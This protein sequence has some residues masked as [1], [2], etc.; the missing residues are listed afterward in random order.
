MMKIRSILCP[1]VCPPKGPYSQAIEVS[2]SVRTIYTGTIT[3][4]D[5]DWNV[6]GKGDIRLQ[7]TKTL[8]NLERILGAAGATLQNIVKMTWY[9]VHI[10]HMTEVA[11]IRNTFFRGHAPA[12][13]TIPINKLFYPD[14]LLEM[15]A[16]AV[17]PAAE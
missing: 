10:E 9:L 12:S 4:L 13:G 8:E 2:G 11:E 1:E 17:L 3:A 7:T 15:D 5:V 6:V 16:I 14:L